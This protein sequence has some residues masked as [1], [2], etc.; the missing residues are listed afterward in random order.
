ML[1][2][3]NVSRSRYEININIKDLLC[4]YHQLHHHQS[5]EQENDYVH[6]LT[7]PC[8]QSTEETAPIKAIINKQV[9]LNFLTKLLT[10]PIIR[11]V[12]FTEV[13]T[14]PGV[15]GFSKK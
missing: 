11:S 14:F 9:N 8:L 12:P 13:L 1:V 15:I 7:D 6:L 3:I 10:N 5:S 2:T 4:Y